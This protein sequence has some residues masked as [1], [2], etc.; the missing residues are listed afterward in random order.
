LDTWTL[1][2]G[3]QPILHHGTGAQWF[4][5][6]INT[7]VA[8]DGAGRWHLLIETKDNLGHNFATGYSYST[9]A[10]GPNFDTHLSAAPVFSGTTGNPW[11]VYVPERQAVL[12]IAGAIPNVTWVL[13]AWSAPVSADLRQAASWTPAPGFGMQTAGIHLTDPSLVFSDVK[14]WGTMLAYHYNQLDAWRVYGPQTAV[15]FFDL[16]TVPTGTQ[17]NVLELGPFGDTRLTRVAPGVVGADIIEAN[18]LRG[19]TRWPN[20]TCAAPAAYFATA[21]QT[22]FYL[23]AASLGAC[24]G[25]V[26]AYSIGPT[27][28]AAKGFA[29]WGVTSAPLGGAN[30]APTGDLQ[31]G[32]QNALRGAAPTANAGATLATA[33]YRHR[34]RYWTV[35][36]QRPTRELRVERGRGAPD[37]D[38]VGL[39][40]LLLRRAYEHADGN[41]GHDGIGRGVPGR[42]FHRAGPEHV[43]DFAVGAR[44][45]A[46][47][48]RVRAAQRHARQVGEDARSTKGYLPVWERVHVDLLQRE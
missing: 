35:E 18:E 8:V 21:P 20:G 47:V 37:R 1:A 10:E 17:S 31:F 45:R 26:P 16:V 30:L 6:L 25:G 15:E 2:N 29:I 19:R 27:G 5:T 14:P 33:P 3:G 24:V 42:V 46:R 44:K 9:L 43:Y 36:S 39:N 22:G 23:D 13:R 40:G 7:A 48:R 12:A 32:G 41:R 38:G 28:L 34:T 11:L 4:Y